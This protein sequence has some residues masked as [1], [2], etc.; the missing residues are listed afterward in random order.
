MSVH[1][2]PNGREVYVVRLAMA[3]T[4]AGVLEG[5]PERASQHLLWSAESRA[6]HLSPPAKPLVV[7][8][9]SQMPLPSWTCVAELESRRGVRSDDPDFNSRLYVCWFTDRTDQS[10]DD[11]IAS[12]LPQVDWEGQA[13]DFDIMDF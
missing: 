13:E 11:M 8:P 4:Y 6:A 10:I 5:T 1:R 2:L 9:P 3:G 7:V 12:V